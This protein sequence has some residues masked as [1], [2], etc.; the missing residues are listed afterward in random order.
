GGGTGP[1]AG[2]APAAGGPAG[3][4]PSVA[5]QPAGATRR[6]PSLRAPAVGALLVAI[7]IVGGLAATS[8]P[9]M[10]LLSSRLRRGLRKEVTPTE[11]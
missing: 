10:Q 8:S 1:A 9:V 3:K 6:T 5:T 4:A 7:L 11:R 2:S